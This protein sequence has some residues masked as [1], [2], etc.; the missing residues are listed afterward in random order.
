[1]RLLPE[2]A[3]ESM[4][5]AAVLHALGDPVRLELARQAL[6]S[7]GLSCAVDGLDVPTSTLTNHWRILREAGVVRMAVDGRRRR[8]WL[9]TDDLNNRFPGLIDPILRLS[10]AESPHSA[11]VNIPAAH[12][13]AG[14][15]AG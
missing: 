13:A 3:P 15:D 5:L 11:P 7:P 14:I 9:R 10:A 12:D 4:T 2:P 6:A 1:M 8:I